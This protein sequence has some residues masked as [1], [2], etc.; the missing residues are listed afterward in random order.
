MVLAVRLRVS[1]VRADLHRGSWHGLS[2]KVTKN[3]FRLCSF[4]LLTLYILSFILTCIG[5]AKVKYIGVKGHFVNKIFVHIIV[6]ATRLK[7]EKIQ[8]FYLKSKLSFL[9]E[10]QENDNSDESLTNSS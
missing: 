8:N 3:C 10:N 4:Y 7:S 6:T 9:T 2:V 5:V 1:V